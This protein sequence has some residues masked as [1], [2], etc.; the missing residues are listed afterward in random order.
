[1]KV[2]WDTR[3]IIFQ[4]FFKYYDFRV[5]EIKYMI[6][7][8]VVISLSLLC[9]L[10]YNAQSLPPLLNESGGKEFLNK[11]KRWGMKNC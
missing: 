11:I 4:I 5:L 1:M 7:R 8:M 3:Y 2:T 6:Y 9:N 10:S